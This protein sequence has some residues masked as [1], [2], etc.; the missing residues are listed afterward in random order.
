MIVSFFFYLFFF[1]TNFLIDVSFIY[2]SNDISEVTYTL[3]VPCSPTH[4]LLLLGPGIPSTGAY[5][6]TRPRAS[7]PNDDQLGHLLLYIQLET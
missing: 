6:F 5:S 3:P 4:P 7:P 1:K 2:I